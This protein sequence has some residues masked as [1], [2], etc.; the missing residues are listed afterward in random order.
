MRSQF[1]VHYG[2]VGTK[3]DNRV[4]FESALGKNL[5]A[6]LADLNEVEV[7][8]KNQRFF[9]TVDEKD[10]QEAEQKISAVF[11][12]AWYSKVETAPLSY[13]SILKTAKELIGRRT[14]VVPGAKDTFRVSVR[15][16][17]KSFGTSSQDLARKL[18]EDLVNEFGL[19]VDLSNPGTELFVDVISD[20]A[21]LYVSKMKGPGGL[22]VG[23]TGRVLH[24][25]SGG[26]D[27]PAGAWLMM[28]RGCKPVYLHFYLAPTP[29]SVV[30]SKIS[31]LIQ[32]LTKF[33]GGTRLI[34]IPF[35][36]YQIATQDLPDDF[37]PTVFRY[38]MRLVAERLAEEMDFP[39]MSTGDNLAQVAS[40][41]LHNLSCMDR[42]SS[43]PVLRPL[44]GYDK[45]EIIQLAKRIGTYE[46]SLVEYKDCCSII[47]RHP[48]TRMRWEYV[49][50][51]ARRFRFGEL[52]SQCILMG[53]AVS[54]AK[55]PEKPPLV[56]PLQTFLD[57]I[58]QRKESIRLTRKNQAPRGPMPG[59]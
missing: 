33:G 39:A 58:E 30:E 17:N 35:A 16:P 47:S 24:L 55:G 56:E 48:R 32:T 27:S 4:V 51:S 23:V 12:V 26:I 29:M 45:D 37:E 43:V 2:E 3:G 8:K 28:K 7:R 6:S 44:L 59:E 34:L 54:F 10:A 5:R 19:G 46:T 22:P 15:R 20:R 38:F 13:D 14:P 42:G 36:P 53:S 50:D 40:Q 57:R 25:L 18:G 31:G 52:V 11:G 41:T 49:E 9:V 21:L 1:V